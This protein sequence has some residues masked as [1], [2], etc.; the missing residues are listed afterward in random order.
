ML[1]IVVAG[2]PKALP[3]VM[4]GSSSPPKRKQAT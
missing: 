1:L 3:R 2:S 4:Y